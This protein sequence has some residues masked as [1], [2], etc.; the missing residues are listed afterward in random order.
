MFGEIYSGIKKTILKDN[1]LL[2]KNI[3]INQHMD[4]AKFEDLFYKVMSDIHIKDIK[5]LSKTA[6]TDALIRKSLI[7]YLISLYL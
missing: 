2:A 4:A 7:L 5:N 3:R 6:M 1:F